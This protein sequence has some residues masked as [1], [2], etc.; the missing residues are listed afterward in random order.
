ML[1]AAQPPAP[2]PSYLELL[3]LPQRVAALAAELDRERAARLRLEQRMERAATGAIA[4][5]ACTPTLLPGGR[6]ATAWIA[7]WARVFK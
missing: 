1:H 6:G 4:A 3:A 7:G 5:G 2:E